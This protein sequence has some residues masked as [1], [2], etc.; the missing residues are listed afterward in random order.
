VQSRKTRN[1]SDGRAIR[2]YLS[3]AVAL[4]VV[5]AWLFLGPNQTTESSQAALGG[6]GLLL[7]SAGSVVLVRGR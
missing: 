3:L 5:A 6:L 4:T 2:R 7:V 1:S